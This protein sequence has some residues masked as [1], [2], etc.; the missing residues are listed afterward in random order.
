VLGVLCTTAAVGAAMFA[1]QEL[2]ADDP[3]WW[4]VAIGVLAGSVLGVVALRRMRSAP[5]PLLN[6]DVL[7]VRS[8]AAVVGF[9]TVYRIGI[10]AVPFLLPLLFQLRFGWSAVAAGAMVTALF[11]GNVAIKPLTT[12]LMRRWG[13]RRVLVA[14]L[15]ASVV[16]FGALA[17]LS[18]TT[19]AVVI[20]TVLVISG[21]LRSI[22]FSAYN[23]LAF[24]DV[25][26]SELSDANAVHAAVQ[27]LGAAFGVALAAVAISVFAGLDVLPAG[28]YS[29]AFVLLGLLMAVCVVG[30]ARLPTAAGERALRTVPTTA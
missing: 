9:G 6:L 29:A 8:F 3:R 13:I 11:V 28:A 25:G 15:T 21:V 4:V 7:Q 24:A 23:T 10:S 5:H 20:G 26:P 30:A 16:S 1:A 2:T 22:G 19:S 12:P 18:A 14:D 17:L 27:E